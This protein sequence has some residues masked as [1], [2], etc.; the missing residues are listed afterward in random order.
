MTKQQVVD[1]AGTPTQKDDYGTII[2]MDT[3]TSAAS[4]KI[5]KTD[6]THFERWRYGPNMEI[7][8]T[9]DL[10]SGVDTNIIMT[11]QRLQQRM[12]SARQ[13]ERQIQE[14]LNREV[15]PQQ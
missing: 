12:D 2:N 15:S 5:I 10:V 1:I 8:F 3:V 13:V 11:Q 14:Q 9:N 7:M 6:S 4:D